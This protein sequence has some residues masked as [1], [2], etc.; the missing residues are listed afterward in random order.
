MYAAI[1]ASEMTVTTATRSPA[2]IVGSARGIST[3]SSIW[4][5]RE[6]AAARRVEDFAETL[7]RP[8]SELVNRISNV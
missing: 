8:A 3:R 6:A 5:R 1:V 4:T 7:A 2:M